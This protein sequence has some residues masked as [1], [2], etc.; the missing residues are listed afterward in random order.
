VKDLSNVLAGHQR[1][2]SNEIS[3]G[4]TAVAPHTDEEPHGEVVDSVKIE[5]EWLEGS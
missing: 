5:E 2:D 4:G 3:A 1:G